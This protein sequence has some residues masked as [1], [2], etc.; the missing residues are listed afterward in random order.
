[1]SYILSKHRGLARVKQ[2]GKLSKG[3]K[4]K[5]YCYGEIMGKQIRRLNRETMRNKNKGGNTGRYN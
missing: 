1:M 5:I 2:G 4:N 3:R